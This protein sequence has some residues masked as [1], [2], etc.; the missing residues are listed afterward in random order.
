MT[1]HRPAVARVQKSCPQLTHANHTPRYAASARRPADLRMAEPPP[2]IRSS[3]C[4]ERRQRRTRAQGRVNAKCLM[5]RVSRRRASN[6]GHSSRDTIFV[7]PSMC[8]TTHAP[9]GLRRSLAFL[10]PLYHWTVS[11]SKRALCHVQTP[12]STLA[13]WLGD[14]W[15]DASRPKCDSLGETQCAYRTCRVWHRQRCIH[16]RCSIATASTPVPG[17]S[18]SIAAPRR[19]L[20]WPPT[21]PRYPI[22]N[23]RLARPESAS[24]PSAIYTLLP[25]LCLRRL[26]K[27]FSW[28]SYR[29][30]H[31][32]L[33]SSSRKGATPDAASTTVPC[34]CGVSLVAT[35]RDIQVGACHVVPS[36][37]LE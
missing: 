19:G 12:P 33:W 21:L 24:P 8:A 14:P 22:T 37:Y 11:A 13:R 10:A 16:R 1:Q 3:L 7:S 29:R 36:L 17:L 9:A 15:E 20:S 34:L 28:Q 35:F 2:P 5:E 27:V 25:W 4:R 26:Q 32:S 18:N 6:P 30:P 23:R 31:P